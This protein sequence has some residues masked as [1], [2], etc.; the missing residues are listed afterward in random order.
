VQPGMPA[1]PVQPLPLLLQLLPG[2]AAA[3]FSPPVLPRLLAGLYVV[4]AVTIEQ[5]DLSLQG[6]HGIPVPAYVP[7]VRAPPALQQS[8]NAS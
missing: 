3:V 4:T 6:A 2:A 7:A 8:H 5:P 1:G